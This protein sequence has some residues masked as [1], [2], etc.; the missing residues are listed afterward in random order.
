MKIAFTKM[1]GAGNDFVLVDNRGGV[2]R[3]DHAKFAVAACDR[4]Y[5]IGADGLLV[6][7]N[8]SHPDFKMMYY[9]AD[10]SYGGMC[11][12][13]GRCAAKYVLNGSGRTT[14]AFEALNHV[15]HAELH[16]EAVS[17]HMKDPSGVQI[18]KTLYLLG[19]PLTYNF[20]NTG[21]PHVV[22]LTKDL[23]PVHQKSFEHSGVNELGRLIRNDQAFSPDGANVNFI[24]VKDGTQVIM[25]TYERGVEDET[26]ACG[27]GSVAS[28]V[29]AA[30]LFNLSSPVDI[31]TRSREHLSISFERAGGKY[32]KAVLTG[33]ARKV[34]DGSVN[35]SERDLV[36]SA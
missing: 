12:N 21:G 35:F 13:G 16:G 4:R 32:Q 8:S 28:A 5:G 29:V 18:G 26:L 2:Y 9:N 7:E 24:E 27:T 33:P 31:L 36:V 15:Y 20:V 30:E 19:E 10:G 22:I 14:T 34:F 17:L 25:R 23:R 11:G 1:T 6:L 3:F